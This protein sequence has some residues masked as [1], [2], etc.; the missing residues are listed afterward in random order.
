M[1]LLPDPLHP[2]VVHFP[3]ALAFVAL[4]FE[5]LSRVRRWRNLEPAAALLV[6]LAALAAVATVLTGS[7]AADSAVV[8]RA[9]ASLLDHHEELGES[10]MWVLLVL[11]AVRILMARMR[12][13]GGWAAWLFLLAFAVAV[14]MVGWNG[15]LGGELVFDH[16]VGT[17]PVQQHALPPL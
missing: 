15:H 13:F 16:G 11:A 7:L 6:V 1:S 8:P 17:T 9:A 5:A 3:I 14:G 10:A 2:A 4:L 12:W